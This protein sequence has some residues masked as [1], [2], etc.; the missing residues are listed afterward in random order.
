M[1]SP[2]DPR[3]RLR[4][5]EKIGEKVIP[6]RGMTVSDWSFGCPYCGRTVRRGGRAEG[7]RKSGFATHVFVCWEVLLF[8]AGYVRTDSTMMRGTPVEPV[9]NLDGSKEWHKRILR[10]L[11][12]AVR[13]RERAGQVP[14]VPEHWR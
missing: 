6:R 4:K 5:G 12:A 1:K 8:Q 11:R 13:N 10:S 7:F 9:S 2:T 14:R 3:T